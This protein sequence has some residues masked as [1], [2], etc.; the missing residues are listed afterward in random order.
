M[1][2]CAMAPTRTFVASWSAVMCK[3]VGSF[4]TKRA[5]LNP[6]QEAAVEFERGRRLTFLELNSRINRLAN[7]LAS[8]GVC[9]GDRL[10]ILLPNSLEYVE[11]YFA[12]AKIGA[13]VVPL[14]WRLVPDELEFIL[15]DSGSSV[16]V[17][18]SAFDGN[19]NALKQ[20]DTSVCTWIRVS[21]GESHLSSAQDY[22]EILQQASESEPGITARGDDLLLLVYTSGTT[23]FPK[24]AMLTHDN[25][26]W[27][28]ITWNVTCDM[29][30]GDRHLIV[31]P[32]FHLG[33]LFPLTAA[34]HRGQ[35]AVILRS[36]EPQHLL[37]SIEREKVTVGVIV[38][39]IL[40][41]ILQTLEDKTYNCTTL[42]WVVAGGEAVPAEL[43]LRAAGLGIEILQDYGLTETCG[44]ATIISSEDAVKKAGSSGKPYF[45]T[46]VRVVADDGRDVSPGEVGEVI[47]RG[48]HAMKGYWN[49]AKATAE[50]IREGWLYTGDLAT[51]DHDGCIYIRD[52][53][54]DMIISGGE[55]IYPAEIERVLQLHSKIREV[56][57]IGQHSAK[58]G[59]SPA[60]IV[61]VKEGAS[62]STEEVLSHCRSRLAGFKLP[63]C[64]EIVSELPRTPTGKVQ[65]HVLRER[66]PGPAPQ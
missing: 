31:L 4:V 41:L 50:T 2:C 24:G 14:N 65:K 57:V 18:G 11:T 40:R 55:N 27:A 59:E 5:Y 39:T 30:A 64:I 60:A 10:A 8:R 43:I 48:P 62:L 34:F 54:K 25:M 45:H 38:T 63:Q 16:L 37:R 56:A 32:L 46:E 53:R 44:I 20:R 26:L 17:Y 58:W 9:K 52:R 12:S 3:S 61:V 1:V 51:I 42:R 28:C 7:G 49:R 22:D 36:A 23:G 15:R 13:V 29:R 6:A 21:D 35:T 66:F 33:G 47:V 19:A